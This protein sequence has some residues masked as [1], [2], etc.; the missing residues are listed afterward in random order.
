MT[1]A[2]APRVDLDPSIR[3]DPALA[4][5]AEQAVERLRGW[6]ASLGP[7]TTFHWRLGPGDGA[8]AELTITE[9]DGDDTLTARDRFPARYLADR[10][11][12][13]S[14][15]RWVWDEILADR[16]DRSTRRTARDI[17]LIV[18]EERARAAEPTHAP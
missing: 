18:A 11:N 14:S 9:P 6:G 13:D 17:A 15:V 12:A 5:L 7:G 8:V 4:A 1:T 3:T 2:A 10:V 16:I